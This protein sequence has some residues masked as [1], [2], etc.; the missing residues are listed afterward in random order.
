MME[1]HAR[2]PTHR[3]GSSAPDGAE[4]APP[5]HAVS[6][7]A[8]SPPAGR[9]TS[10]ERWL[11]RAVLDACGSP[12]I[13]IVLWDGAV[14]CASTETLIGSLRIHDRAALCRMAL[15]PIVG[16][17]D[18]F[19]EGRIE[20]EGN[21]VDVLCAMSRAFTSV[22]RQGLVARMLNRKPH[23][24][25]PHTLAAS[26]DSVHHHYDIGNSFYKH[27]L[28]KNLLYTCAYYSE[29]AMTLE[30][31]QVAKMD[32]ICR[33][34][35]LRS[36]DRVIEAGCG[37][38]G[39]ALHMAAR[40][41]AHVR[42]FNLSREQVVH[43]REW[44]ALLGLASKVEFIE[45]DYRNVTGECDAFVS[46][47]MLE[48]VGLENFPELGRVIDRVLTPVGRGLI[49]SIGR[50][51]PAPLDPWIDRRIFPGAY[52]PALSEMMQLFEPARL[53]VLDVENL[54]MHYARTLEHWL[55]RYE[56]AEPQ[57]VEMFDEKFYRSWRLY[58]AGSI[59]AFAVGSLQLFQV[60]FAR[61]ENNEI[62]TTRRDVYVDSPA[63]ANGAARTQV[64]SKYYGDL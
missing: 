37:W 24:R 33:K 28:D 29:P 19:S 15:R 49:H 27:W 64:W 18:G 38:G 40:Y 41:G 56:R 44:A 20:V 17:G 43:A 23:I 54:R 4:D 45:D 60:V 30:E 5:G 55:E 48:H 58:L 39:F 46:V 31:A 9:S 8:T 35:H 51:A 61:Q 25:R 36:G 7:S 13:S 22:R 53:S 6:R 32:H 62:P 59:A 14:C 42:A 10:L 34:I 1:L 57:I 2:T 11:M 16:F 52:P 26:R 47:G 63:T 12:P 3:A 50:N 21:L